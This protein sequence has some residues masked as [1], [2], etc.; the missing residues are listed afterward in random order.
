[1]IETAFLDDFVTLVGAAAWSDRLA[2][3]TRTGR[4]PTHAGR[5]TL[6]RHCIEF[7]IERLRHTPL[8]HMPSTA[9]RCVM[10]D[11]AGGLS[12]FSELSP[13]G[14]EQF[15]ARLHASLAG[16]GCLVDFFH[17][18]RIAAMRRSQGFEVQF[19]GFELGAPFDLLIRRRGVAAEVSC[20]VLS[21]EDGRGIQRRAWL[22]LMDGLDREL[23]TWLRANPGRFLMKI[24]LHDHLQ[25]E[26]DAQHATVRDR[27][28]GMLHNRA[29]PQSEAE[30][31]IRLEPLALPM[32]YAD[33]QSLIPQLR[34]AFGP[35]AHLTVV[36]AGGSVLALAARA[37]CENDIA[38]AV[39]RHLTTAASRRLSGQHP[40]IMALFIEDLDQREWRLLRDT[41]QLEGEVRQ[42]M[43]HEAASRVAAVSCTSRLE[44]FGMVSAGAEPQG[45][46]RFR[47]PAHPFAR[48][49][50]LAPAVSSSG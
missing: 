5:A 24:T 35:E 48:L 12:T 4:T 9:E 23:Q 45:E 37:G 31:T 28:L 26:D 3:L 42:F 47:N 41:L 49:E 21:A 14:R 43:T 8:D 10:T 46:V 29:L 32:Q 38:S 13:P 44:L 2:A 25:G 39:N 30:A 17:L 50:A 15:L 1:M 36:S 20:D 22:R 16:Q 33:G 34:H 18:L 11:A 7:V 40:G 19:A 6:Q 27:I